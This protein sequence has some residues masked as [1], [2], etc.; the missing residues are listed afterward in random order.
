MTVLDAKLSLPFEIA[1]QRLRYVTTFRGQFTDDTLFYIDD[2]TLGSRYTVRGFDGETLLAAERGYYWPPRIATADR[3]HRSRAVR[4]PSTT[5]RCSAPNAAFLDGT[6]LA[7]AAI[8]LRGGVPMR[9]GAYA[10][11]L[12]AGTPLY[13]PP[14]FPGGRVTLGFSL[15]SDSE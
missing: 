5:V 15:L 11:E 4:R 12:F 2:F 7:D 3:T 1:A 10:Y 14:G 8:G 9:F 13:K 6:Q